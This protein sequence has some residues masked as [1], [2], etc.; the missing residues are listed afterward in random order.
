MTG[1]PLRLARAFR[2]GSWRAAGAVSAV[3]LFFNLN[4]LSARYHGRWDWTEDRRHTLSAP[5]LAALSGLEQPLTAWLLLPPQDPRSGALERMLGRYQAASGSGFRVRS[6]DP[7]QQEALFRRLAEQNGLGDPAEL[8]QSAAVVL[9]YAGRSWVLREGDARL[10][11]AVG[12][13]LER[14]L[15]EGV[16]ALTRGAQWSVC[17]ARGADPAGRRSEEPPLPRFA[18]ALRRSNF[19]LELRALGRDNALQG[20]S[21][22]VIAPAH[23][24]TP[25]AAVSALRAHAAAGG[26]LLVVVG[27]RF[28]DH[29]SVIPSPLEPLLA[30]HGLR[31]LPRLV[32]ESDPESTLAAA[33]SG[34]I[35][36]AKAAPHPITRNLG[37]P[38]LLVRMARPIERSAFQVERRLRA[39]LST[40]AHATAVSGFAREVGEVPGPFTVAWAVESPVDSGAGSH[41]GRLVVLGSSQWL[42]DSLWGDPARAQERRFVEEALT[43]LGERPLTNQVPARA[44]RPASLRLTDASMSRVA[45]YAIVY[46]PGGALLLGVLVALRRRRSALSDTTGPGS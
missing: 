32:I 6:L 45:R 44:G 14:A 11:Q 31:V 20:C 23:A 30:D 1:S 43:W 38:T 41:K 13:R 16:Q 36:L 8:A 27:A 25:P 33:S 34:E 7:A 15:T 4:L 26:R 29:Q 2:R 12:W 22:T 35:F 17:L 5:T 19:V 18:A 3:V 28:G 9:T 21:L 42:S 46:L 10:R 39:L 24:P 40:S 37:S